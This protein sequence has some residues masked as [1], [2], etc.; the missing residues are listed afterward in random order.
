MSWDYFD[1]AFWWA[2]T[3]VFILACLIGL[4]YSAMEYG[5]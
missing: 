5:L 2:A 4:H 1:E 3:S